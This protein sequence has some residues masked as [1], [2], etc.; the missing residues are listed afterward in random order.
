MGGQGFDSACVR[1][2]EKSWFVVGS[3]LYANKYFLF[4]FFT[5]IVSHIGVPSRMQAAFS[6]LVVP[7]LLPVCRNIS[8]PEEF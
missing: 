3:F 4:A 1:P 6:L 5:D 2:P 8:H 7:I